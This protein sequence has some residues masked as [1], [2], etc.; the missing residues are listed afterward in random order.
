[1]KK[2][3]VFV[4][5]LALV[6]L[7]LPY[8]TGRVAESVSMQ[9]ADEISKTPL[10]TGRLELRDYQR[11]FFSTDTKVEWH[12]P[13]AQQALFDKKVIFD[14]HGSHGLL[15]Y[16]F[17]CQAENLSAYS[18]FVATKLGGV[19]PVKLS[20]SVSIFGNASQRIE[21]SPFSF[22]D[23]GATIDVQAGEL[24]VSADKSLS[25]FDM[26]GEFA[27]MT[28]TGE[29]GGM[30]IEPM[31]LSGDFGLNQH[32][33]LIGDFVLTMQGLAVDSQDDGLLLME[34]LKV[35]TETLE[36]GD[37]LEMSYVV[38]MDSLAL[39]DPADPEPL[40]LTD[41]QM[42][43]NLQGLNMVEFAQF[44]NYMREVAAA[45]QESAGD[46]SDDESDA[47]AQANQN[48]QMLSLL[49]E[50]EDL[51]TKGLAMDMSLDAGHDGDT[52][53]GKLELTLLQ[54]LALGD[55]VLLTV[56]PEAFFRKIDLALFNRIPAAMFEAYEE[57]EQAIS[58]TG[59]YR[60]QGDY[61]EIDVRVSE[62]GIM[63]N[64]QTLS[65]E[66]L[67]S[68]LAPTPTQS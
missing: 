40:E 51:L 62:A 29:E 31:A 68:L 53:T 54:D 52:T 18:E 34:E 16:A 25:N 22:E 64:G 14:C 37:D 58:S 30:N 59:L 8:L 33:L 38:E 21:L 6:L 65:I 12:V 49:P 66:E 42:D 15:K 3:I 45:A 41:M 32:E 46:E 60:K 23:K 61:Y 35:S 67:F 55:F 19:D 2:L 7:G 10:E 50:L 26:T 11:G 27:G 36:N 56:Q 28:V 17:E 63:L 48:A 57:N 13:F 20:G 5:L 9:M 24:Q 44:S 39:H 47:N 4:V 1:M 43:F